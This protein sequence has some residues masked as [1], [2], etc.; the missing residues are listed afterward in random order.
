MFNKFSFLLLS[1]FLI[2][3]LSGCNDNKNESVNPKFIRAKKLNDRNKY[4]EAVD[5]F[6][7]YLLINPRSIQAHMYLADLYYDHLD[8]PLNAIYHYRQVLA[9][10]PQSEEK[11]VIG[12]YIEN[13]EKR[14]YKSL[15]K[16]Y[17]EEGDIGMVKKELEVTKLKAEK[18]RKMAKKYYSISKLLN[19]KLKIAQAQ[20]KAKKLALL[21]ETNKRK[22]SDKTTI[23]K[24]K[25]TT[26]IQRGAS[27]TGQKEIVAKVLR[28]TKTHVTPT[29]YVIQP[30][31]NLM[32]ISEKVYGSTKYFKKIFQA[33]LDVIP[34]TSQLKVGQRIVIPKL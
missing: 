11:G 29:S 28:S 23:P 3:L 21:K 16:R 17:A 4:A 25:Q 9:L 34:S 1:T 31:D 8:E 2:L 30:G 20:L 15:E 14:Y 22:I 26:K 7:E 12:K 24:R 6:N 19:K 18:Y 33:N 32:I 5:A 10:D 27:H 13:A